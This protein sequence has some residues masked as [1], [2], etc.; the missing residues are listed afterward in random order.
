MRFAPES[1]PYDWSQFDRDERSK[2][3]LAGWTGLAAGEDGRRTFAS[4]GRGP[5]VKVNRVGV[6]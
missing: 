4:C 3:R 2:A 6:L 5:N 1:R